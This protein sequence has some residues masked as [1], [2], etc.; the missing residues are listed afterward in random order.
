MLQAVFM[1]SLTILTRT[2]RRKKLEVKGGFYS[3]EDMKTELGYSPTP[4]SMQSNATFSVVAS[5]T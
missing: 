3:R 1:E 2:E 4:D 5:P